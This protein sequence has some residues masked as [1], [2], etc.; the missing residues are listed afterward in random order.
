MKFA[1]EVNIYQTKSAGFD[2]NQ[3]QLLKY[4]LNDLNCTKVQL[5]SV[6]M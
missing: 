4:V 5:N 6:T 2:G 1:C 3:S